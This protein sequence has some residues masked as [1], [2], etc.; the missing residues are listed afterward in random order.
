MCKRLANMVDV[1]CWMR[2]DVRYRTYMRESWMQL[3]SKAA[4]L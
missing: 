3:D 2:A 1:D 4:L